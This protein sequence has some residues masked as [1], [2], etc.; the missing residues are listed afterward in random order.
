[1]LGENATFTI[2][3]TG[4]ELSYQWQYKRAGQDDW[5]DWAGKTS[6]TLRFKGTATNNGYQ[7][8][9]VVTNAAGSVTSSAATLTV[10]GKPVITTQPVDTTVVLGENATFTVEATGD[11][12]SYQ[13]QYK[14]TGQDD[15]NDWAGKTSATLRFKGT[16]TNNAYQYRCVVSNA[17]GSVESDA[18]TLTVVASSNSVKLEWA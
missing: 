13:W 10:M 4:D 18:V 1:M 16:A 15:W 8:R 12:L 17:I 14:R 6:A 9:C 11:E 7:Y 3:A 5:N 2:E